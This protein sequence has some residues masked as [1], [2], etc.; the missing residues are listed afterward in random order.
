[1]LKRNFFSVLL[2]AIGIFYSCTSNET[3]PTDHSKEIPVVFQVS[4][5]NVETQPMSKNTTSGSNISDIVNSIS[6]YIF[7]IVR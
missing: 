6:I 2:L 3:E 1:M 5:L 7:T 4:T